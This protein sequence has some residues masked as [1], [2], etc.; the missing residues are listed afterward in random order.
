[1]DREELIQKLLDQDS[2]HLKLKQQIKSL[3]E[4]NAGLATKLE[5]K[6]KE[7]MNNQQ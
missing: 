2:K 5:K 1:M 3:Q 4:N 6:T 7:N